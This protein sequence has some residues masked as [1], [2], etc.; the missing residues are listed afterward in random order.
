M[1]MWF[2]QE[3]SAVFFPA[4]FPRAHQL[5]R[6]PGP[7][8]V[9]VV[10]VVRS[11]VLRRPVQAPLWFDSEHHFCDPMHNDKSAARGRFCRSSGGAQSVRTGRSPG[12]SGRS[13][14][15][16]LFWGG[17]THERDRTVRSTVFYC[18]TPKSM[19]RSSA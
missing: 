1:A 14:D 11:S 16:G 18:F 17:Q 8:P 6:L 13:K 10:L 4:H 2:H 3:V 7:S 19:Q 12:R 5:P 15:T 9:P